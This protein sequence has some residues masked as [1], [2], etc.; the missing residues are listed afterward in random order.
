M[1]V[2]NKSAVLVD[3]FAEEIAMV[4]TARWKLCKSLCAFVPTEWSEFCG[5]YVN[6]SLVFTCGG[7][8]NF[9]LPPQVILWSPNDT[10]TVY[11]FSLTKSTRG[12]L[13]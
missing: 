1:V 4:N 5:D 3:W 9:F 13:G 2:L 7:I 10:V 11:D 12:C 8:T 6:S